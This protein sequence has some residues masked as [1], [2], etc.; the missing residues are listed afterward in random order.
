MQRGAF[1]RGDQVGRRPRAGRLRD[2]DA[3]VRAQRAGDLLDGGKRLR[4]APL[5]EIA[6][7]HRDAKVRD[8][9]VEIRGRGLGRARR[10]GG[11][12]GIGPLQGVVGQGEISGRA[13]HRAEMV[14]AAHEGEAPG[15][16]EPPVGGLEPEAAAEGGGHADRAV[17]VGGQRDRHQAGGD[18][19]T[20]SPRGA[21]GHVVEGVRV[22][23]IAVVDVLAGEVVGVFAHAE[24]PD[25]HGARRLQ[26]PDQG[27]VAG[28]RRPL[29]V[30]PRARPRR[31]TGDVEEVLD[32]E[33]HPGEGAES[34]APGPRGV[35]GSGA[36]GGALGQAVG[37]A[38]HRRVDARDAREG[39]GDHVAGAD[40]PRRHRT[41]DVAGRG[42]APIRRRAHAV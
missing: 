17:G 31:Q 14:E 21:A 42:E 39:G 36:G 24:G 22:A 20:R 11:I 15:P 7:G 28:S 1:G 32:R 40:R 33:G 18:R 38:V 19:R 13:R 5:R 25:Q 35:E 29:A 41:G 6:S 12:L 4:V 10:G 16:A 26:P 37:E 3:A 34:V 23:C 9:P 2:R 27:G 30:D 8:A